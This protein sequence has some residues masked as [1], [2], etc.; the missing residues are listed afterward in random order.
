V[1]TVFYPARL[2]SLGR[3]STQHHYILWKHPI[4]RDRVIPRSP[5]PITDSIQ[6][7]GYELP[8]TLLLRL[9]GKSD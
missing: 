1:E 6:D 7:R 5:T 2:Y 8:R 9:F 3:I 4:H